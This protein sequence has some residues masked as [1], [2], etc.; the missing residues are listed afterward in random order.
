LATSH[1]GARIAWLAWP[2]VR[3]LIRS[4]ENGA[5]LALL[6]VLESEHV[7]ERFSTV[8]IASGDG[9]F[10]D[11]AAA[12]QTADCEVRVVCRHGALSRRLALAVRA[13]IFVDI[14]DLG[15]P[16]QAVRRPARHRA[17]NVRPPPQVAGN[18]KSPLGPRAQL[19]LSAP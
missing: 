19:S 16:G 13:Q 1:H 18:R 4:G 8:I 11:P 7:P 10:A 9:I 15:V 14:D 5:D 2:N 17:T 12:L 6:D 3:R